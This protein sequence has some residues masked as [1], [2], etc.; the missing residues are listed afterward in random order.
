LS[1]A[2]CLIHHNG[3]KFD[4]KYVETRM[5]VH[6]L[7]P[8]PPIP[9]ID[10]YLVAKNRFYFNSNKLAYLGGLL[11]V[12]KK[13]PTTPGL[14]MEVLKGNAEAIKEMV[15]YNKQDVALLERVFLKLQPFVANHVN[16][17]LYGGAGC[18]RCGSMK[19]Q[20]RGTYYALT[21]T[22]NRYCCNSCHGWFR[23]LKADSGST[24]SRVL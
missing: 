24:T 10:T 5:L 22:Y 12:G 8:L 6:G 21:R 23:D 14:W 3:N 17:Q 2:D 19:I 1:G 11:G 9:M 4:I 13:M 18:P 15:K 16:R 20:S 7:P